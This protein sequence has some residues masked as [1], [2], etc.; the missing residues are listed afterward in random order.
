M[1]LVVQHMY[2]FLIIGMKSAKPNSFSLLFQVGY[3]RDY[4]LDRT[5][6]LMY[7]P[8]YTCMVP[9]IIQHELLHVLGI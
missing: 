7:A 1:D 5:V 4:V 3:L 8:P 6:T 2:I 9:G